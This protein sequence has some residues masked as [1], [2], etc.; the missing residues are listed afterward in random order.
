MARVYLAVHKDVPNLKVVLKILSDARM[1][2]RFRQEA[3]KL[4]LLDGHASVCRIKHFFNHGEDF[5]IAMEYIDGTTLEDIIKE[6]GKIPLPEAMKI[7]SDVLSTLEFAHNKDIYHRDIKPGNIMVDT[8]GVVKIIDFGIAKGKTDPN[9]TVA[10]TSCGTPAY[11]P[12][13]Q[14]NPTEEIDYGLV[15]IYAVGTTLFHMLT[16]ELPFKAENQFALR[17]AK[18]FNDPPSPRD[19][20][21]DIPRKLEAII[22]KALDRA[23]E[24]RYATAA[25]M[26]SAIDALREQIDSSDIKATIS[27][28]PSDPKPKPEKTEGKN[29]SRPLLLMAPIIIVIAVAIYWTLFLNKETSPPEPPTL[30]TPVAGAILSSP[31]PVFSWQGSGREG[32]SYEVE[33]GAG[34]DLSRLIEK[35]SLTSTN[36]S[37]VD[38]LANGDYSWRVRAVDNE[39]NTARPSEIRRFTIMVEPSTTPRGTLNIVVKPAGDIYIDDDVYD[40][41]KSQVEVALDTGWHRIQAVNNESVEQSRSDSIYLAEDS[42]ESV[43]F[44]FSFPE[45]EPEPD[46]ASVDSGQVIVGSRP[47]DGGIIFI[48]GIKQDETTNFTF[49]LPAGSHEIKVILVLDGEEVE[50][51]KTVEV[52]KNQTVTA[53][54]DFR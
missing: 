44:E 52:I 37:P 3:D 9:L 26:K 31:Y 21:P 42:R 23:P 27:T 39:G 18:L 47:D 22:L 49:P 43:V 2:E 32:V 33:L 46:K 4:A 34:D 12:P 14:F 5:V 40:R 45:V 24:K 8:S 36:Y 38:S 19:I 50:K 16:G 20:N 10:G 51:T 48:D 28:P 6:D 1:V 35:K 29:Y 11:M 54:F 13:E 53:M 30:L 41:R 15:D 25:E 17:D 7:A